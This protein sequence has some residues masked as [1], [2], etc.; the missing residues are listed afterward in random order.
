MGEQLESLNIRELQQLE[1]QLEISLK[2]VRSRKVKTSLFSF[3]RRQLRKLYKAFKEYDLGT[4][5]SKLIE[6]V[7]GAESSHVRLHC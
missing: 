7:D 2:H 6:S 3:S 5:S 4:M 1:H